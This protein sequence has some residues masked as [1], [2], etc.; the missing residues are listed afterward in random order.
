MQRSIRSILQLY[1]L[2]QGPDP[3]SGDEPP[4][5]FGN[6]M[7]EEERR[8]LV[9]KAYN[10]LKTTFELF[11]KPDGSKSAPAKTCRDLAVAYP[12][13]PNGIWE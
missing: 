13:L 1:L 4:R 3:L 9:L 5:L 8:A 10:H 11:K 7:S 2:L 6:D 12:S